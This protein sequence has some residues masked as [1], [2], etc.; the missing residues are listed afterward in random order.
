MN[1][2]RSHLGRGLTTVAS[3]RDVVV[4]LAKEIATGG[5]SREKEILTARLEK[6]TGV[7]LADLAKAAKA[8]PAA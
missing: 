7:A 1:V 2:V 6:V 3:T 5:A 8:W 4:D